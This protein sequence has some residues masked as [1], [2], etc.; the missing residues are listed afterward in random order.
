[1]APAQRASPPPQRAAA[2]PAPVAASP[3]AVGPVAPQGP[4]KTTTLT[5]TDR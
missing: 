5:L 3:S 4:S 2:P 1:M